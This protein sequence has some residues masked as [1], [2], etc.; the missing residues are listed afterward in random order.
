MT[1]KLIYT[2][3]MNKPVMAALIKLARVAARMTLTPMEAIKGF[4]LGTMV[5]RT[6][7]IAA[8]AERLAKPA[9]AMVIMA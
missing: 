6:P 5:P 3:E 7:I 1:P 2:K 4:I 8:G 9:S